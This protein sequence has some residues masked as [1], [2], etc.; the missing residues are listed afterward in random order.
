MSKFN[1][2]ELRL[3][4][5]RQVESVERLLTKVPIRK[6]LKQA[7]NRV[8]PDEGYRINIGLL[9]LKTEGETYI[10]S[11]SLAAELVEETT[12]VCLFTTVDRQGEVFLWPVK[13]PDSLGKID[14][15]NKSAMVGAQ[16]AME[17]W[18]R[19]SAN[20]SLGCYEVFK[21]KGELEEPSWPIKTFDELI[22][23]AFKDYFIDSL[24]HPVVKK[25]RGEM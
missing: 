13:L 22:E 15:W 1:L 6:P 16:H 8:H 24:D 12:P 21:A 10:V 4:P 9:Q 7:F 2:E 5:S 25:L 17:D 3:D 14:E 20:R 23:I 18:V 11:P 19:V